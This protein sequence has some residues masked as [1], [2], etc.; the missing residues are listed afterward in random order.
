MHKKSLIIILLI[1]ITAG[2]IGGGLVYARRHNQNSAKPTVVDQKKNA[3]KQT[4]AQAAEDNKTSQDVPVSADLSVTNVRASEQGSAVSA[5][6][7]IGGA[8]DVSGNCVFTF[9]NDLAKPVVRQV[10]PT[11]GASDLS[12]NT[13]DI[14]NVEFSVIGT[15]KLTVNYYTNNQQASGTGSIDIN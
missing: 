14:N 3:P 13:G 1:I 12:C 2:A 4:A 8:K 5:S 6:A 7:D 11:G 15:W 9:S 10:A